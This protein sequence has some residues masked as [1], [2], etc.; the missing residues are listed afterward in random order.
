MEEEAAV[1]GDDVVVVGA[2]EDD[3][4]ARARDGAG[5]IGVSVRG[6]GGEERGRNF[7]LLSFVSF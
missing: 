5:C 1:S 6:G 7:D 3:D 2:G 4:E